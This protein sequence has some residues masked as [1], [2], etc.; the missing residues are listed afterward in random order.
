LL[1]LRESLSHCYNALH[2]TAKYLGTVCQLSIVKLSS[3]CQMNNL[4]VE[5]MV[6]MLDIQQLTFSLK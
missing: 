3:A 5:K 4:M 1:N 6:S 2:E